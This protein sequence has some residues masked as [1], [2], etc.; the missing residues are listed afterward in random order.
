MLCKAAR[1]RREPTGLMPDLMSL[2]SS[3]R[4][5][6]RL[7]SSGGSGLILWGVVASS[8]ERT[9]DVANVRPISV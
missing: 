5:L 2:R 8:S 9:V 1:R 3:R 4:V 6:T 7:G